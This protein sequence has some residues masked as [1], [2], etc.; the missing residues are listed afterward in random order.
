MA[1]DNTDKGAIFAPKDDT[2]V[3][4]GSGY[5]SFGTEKRDVMVY[6]STTS[7]GRK[8]YKIY[9]ELCAVFNNDDK[10]TDKHPD[11]SGTVKLNNNDYYI[12]MWNNTSKAGDDYLSVSVSRKEAV[13]AKKNIDEGTPF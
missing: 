13:E 4:V 2:P 3:L 5:I 12:S 1:Y 11:K 7:S 8:I 6:E 9:H 10:K